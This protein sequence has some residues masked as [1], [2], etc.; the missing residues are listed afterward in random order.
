LDL[1]SGGKNN[2]DRVFRPYII[3]IFR[4]PSFLVTYL[5]FHYN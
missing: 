2:V 3:S 1:I 4:F 5:L